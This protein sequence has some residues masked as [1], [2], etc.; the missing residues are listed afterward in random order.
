LTEAEFESY[1]QTQLMRALLLMLGLTACGME[2]P[3]ATALD[4]QRG[5][6]ALEQLHEGRTL[7]IEK[8][9]GC[10]RPPLPAEKAAAAWPKALDEMSERSKLDGRQRHMIEKYLVVMASNR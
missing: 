9:G 8:C 10:H 2:P 5:N 1:F 7:M 4:A 3:R 6:I